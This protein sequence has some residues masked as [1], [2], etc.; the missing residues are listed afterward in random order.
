MKSVK[1]WTEEE[2]EK[3]IYLFLSGKSILQVAEELSRTV[4]SVGNKWLKRGLHKK[5]PG[6][7]YQPS[8]YRHI[9]PKDSISEKWRQHP[10]LK[11]YYFSELGNAWSARRGMQLKS[12][13]LSTDVK[14]KKGWWLKLDGKARKV[15]RLV[16][17]TW[18][19]LKDDQVVLH[20]N[21]NS[22]DNDIFNLIVTDKKRAGQITG[23]FSKSIPVALYREDKV[24]RVFRSSRDA[25]KHLG[26]SY[27]TVLDYA[28]DRVSRPLYDIRFY[29]APKRARG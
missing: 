27:Q 1:I 19:E 9:A 15:S 26:I 3:M 12:Y 6:I 24:A 25:A 21:R 5:Y 16:A 17:E 18:L 23:H 10:K 4:A 22:F 13:K 2:V 29:Q 7:Q 20:K 8:G 28:H 14:N 11:N